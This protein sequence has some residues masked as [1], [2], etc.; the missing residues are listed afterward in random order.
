MSMAKH[1]VPSW[2]MLT[3][4]HYTTEILL[5]K[6]PTPN[7]NKQIN[8]CRIG[9]FHGHSISWFSPKNKYILAHLNCWFQTNTFVKTFIFHYFKP[10]FNAFSVCVWFFWPTKLEITAQHKSMISQY[11]LKSDLCWLNNL[12]C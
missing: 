11:S 8:Y 4:I 12:R 5:N 1:K 6:C 9:Y 10:T 7:T 3:D 2:F